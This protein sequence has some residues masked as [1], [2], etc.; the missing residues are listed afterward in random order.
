MPE[1]IYA[2]IWEAI[3]A[4]IPGHPAQ[5]RGELRVS[6]RD[7][8]CK[9]D[10]LAQHF[11]EAG[12]RRGSKV[13][14]YLYNA[15][16]YLET[17]F[18]A[19]KVG[20]AP[21]NTNYRYGGDELVYVFDNADAEAVVF[22]ASF[23]RTVEAIRARLPL[24]KS[25]IC[26]SEPGFATP[27]WAVDYTQL[28]ARR[29]AR[30]TAA[31]GR[32]PEDLLLLYTGGTTGKPK[33]VMWRQGD[34]LQGL[35]GGA[36]LL[37]GLPALTNATE[38]GARAAEFVRR[39]TPGWPPTTIPAAPLMHAT[40]LFVA[41]GSLVGGGTIASLPGTRFS[42]PEM[43]DEIERVQ[44]TGIVIV[45]MAFAVPMLEALEAEPKRWHMRS[46]RRIISSGTI[47][48]EENKQAILRH[49]PDVM[50]ID[51]LGSSE[52]LGI[53][54]SLTTGTG[55]DQSLTDLGLD[56][57]RLEARTS[58][59][60]AEQGVA[61]NQGSLEARTEQNAA[62]DQHALEPRAE[63]N[64]AANQRAIATPGPSRTARFAVGA[65]TAVFDEDGKRVT[66]GSGQRGLVASR[67]FIPVGYYKDAAQSGKT[68]R[69]FEGARWAVPGDYAMVDADGSIVLL[70]R[71]ALVI[72]TGGEKVFPEEVEETLK[73]YPG[74]RDA[75]VIGLSDPRFG[76]RICA[77]VELRDGVSVTLEALATHVRTYLAPYK[78]PR[79]LIVAPVLRHANGKLDYPGLRAAV[80]RLR[81]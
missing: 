8:D 32:S 42:A 52:A 9:A 5:I 70:G 77:V 40:G 75:A 63:Q 34:L 65:N 64:A 61:A 79:E 57:G 41:L 72:N 60:R 27:S 7:F 67:G 73:R 38:A 17:Y 58:R 55:S 50:L 81:G 3:A 56:Q 39:G 69:N 78:V 45:G 43:F 49:L 15:P 4:A 47:W 13:A 30:A 54:A 35:G 10:A 22:H 62:A 2:D 31:W 20:L 18:A 23:A 51:S 6:W 29:V 48:S 44:A 25:W 33:G 21:F 16:E 74:I 46:L 12:L 1:L 59:A 28:T 24:V 14:A 68:F 66:P 11:L 36:N 53:G 80:A 71:G 37:M 26:V 76:E 19:F